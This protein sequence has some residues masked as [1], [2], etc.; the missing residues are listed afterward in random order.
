M[1]SFRLLNT[2]LVLT[3]LI[4]LPLRAE[5]YSREIL[6]H[7]Q[8]LDAL[9]STD[10]WRSL[11]ITDPDS[12]KSSGH[13][14]L[15]KQM[16]W[17]LSQKGGSC[18]GHS[19]AEILSAAYH[20]ATH[21]PPIEVDGDLLAQWHT[22]TTSADMAIIFKYV[23]SLFGMLGN[24]F[25]GGWDNLVINDAIKKDGIF[26]RSAESVAAFNEVQANSSIDKIF[27]MTSEPSEVDGK[28]TID[29]FAMIR[30]RVNGIYAKHEVKRLQFPKN[31]TPKLHELWKD[32][33]YISKLHSIVDARLDFDPWSPEAPEQMPRVKALLHFIE[34]YIPIACGIVT[35]GV[36]HT[37][38]GGKTWEKHGKEG[39]DGL[40]AV[41]LM[42]YA[43][44]EGQLHWIFR[45]HW[46][47]GGKSYIRIPFDESFRI[48]SAYA[49]LLP[50]EEYLMKRVSVKKLK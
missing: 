42:G 46:E 21:L 1:F 11:L 17:S 19:A 18:Y 3:L 30:N 2:A 26:V 39:A 29:I 27:A 36:F 12:K 25:D 28:K 5:N 10:P 14:L 7:A 34:N 47:T 9:N 48:F 15:I 41:A 38:D 45:N 49:L 24:V 6:R 8:S 33:T 31:K 16:P 4:S 32:M 13:Y 43:I 40:H 23:T 20:R 50:S 44:F 37:K 22:L 35:P